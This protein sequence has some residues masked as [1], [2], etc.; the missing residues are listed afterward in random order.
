[1]LD[2]TLFL[3]GQDGA[4]AD[5]IKAEVEKLQSFKAALA[6]ATAA[7]ESA[8]TFDRKG[9]QCAVCA[10]SK[11]AGMTYFEVRVL[12]HCPSSLI[13]LLYL[14]PP[15]IFVVNVLMLILSFF[16]PPT[17]LWFVVPVCS[18]L[19]SGTKKGIYLNHLKCEAAATDG[20]HRNAVMSSP[21]TIRQLRNKP[22]VMVLML[23]LVHT[24]LPA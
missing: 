19:S 12:R 9:V 2:S 10:Y 20:P 7:V 15:G 21:S 4:A 17:F 6:A 18:W 3:D 1:M 23:I 8:S 14:I 22:A 24:M 16:A 11:Y 5:A 13:P